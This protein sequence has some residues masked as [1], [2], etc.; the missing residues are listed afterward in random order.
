MMIIY[1]SILIFIILI[2]I[3]FTLLKKISRLKSDLIKVREISLDLTGSSEQVI[4][5]SKSLDQS[6][7]DQLESISVTISST[8]EISSMVSRTSDVSKELS[9]ESNKLFNLSSEGTSVVDGMVLSSKEMENETMRFQTELIEGLNELR[10]VLKF[11]NEISA[12]TNMINDIVFQTKL[13]SFNASVEAARAGEHGKGFAVVAEEVG[14]LAQMSGKTASEINGIVESSVKQV[15]KM[16]S[17]TISKVDLLNKNMSLKSSDGVKKSE[18]CASIF[19]NLKLKVGEINE[20][21]REISL[22]SSEQAIGVMQL[23][24]SISKLQESAERNRLTAGQSFENAHSLDQQV[25]RSNNLLEVIVKYLFNNQKMR[26]HL[27][28]FIWNDKYLIGVDKMDDEHKILVD[29]INHLVV[30]LDQFQKHNDSNK[31]LTAFDAMAS[32]T[33]EHFKDEEDFM[34]SFNYPQLPSH[35]KIHQ[36]LLLQVEAY[37][38]QIIDGTLNDQKLVSFLRNWL[39]SHI[40]GIDTKYSKHFKDSINRNQIKEKIA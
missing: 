19:E 4:N 11:I 28:Q 13:L 3:I 26:Q 27:D 18:Q 15:E 34:R 37:R 32:Y 30:E 1:V 22:A 9:H 35:S 2:S 5:A 40:M 10:G 36:Q 25:H 33:V 29:K 39:V 16:L 7:S 6:S 12:K 31:V 8:H 38:T 21:I 23:E 14:K 24:E 20:K 17:E